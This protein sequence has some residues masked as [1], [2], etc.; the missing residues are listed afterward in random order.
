MFTFTFARIFKRVLK[1]LA[2]SLSV[3][4]LEA[5]CPRKLGP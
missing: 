4:G 2:L 5:A 1:S 3:L